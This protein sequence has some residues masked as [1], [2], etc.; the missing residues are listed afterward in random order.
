MLLSVNIFQGNC[1]PIVFKYKKSQLVSK[2]LCYNFNTH[3]FS[4]D[5]SSKIGSGKYRHLYS[6][7]KLSVKQ[8]STYGDFTMCYLAWLKLEDNAKG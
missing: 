1:P 6:S 7:G 2:C 5:H 3:G 8:L 4:I